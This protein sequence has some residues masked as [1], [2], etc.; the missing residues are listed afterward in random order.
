MSRLIE[1]FNPNSAV[2]GDFASNLVNGCG[3]AVLYNES[4]YTLVLTFEDGSEDILLAWT[5]DVFKARYPSPRIRWRRY[6]TLAVD[7]SPSTRVFGVAYEPSETIAGMYPVG[8]ARGVYVGNTVATNANI[9]NPYLEARV[10]TSTVIGVNFPT[11]PNYGDVFYHQ[12]YGVWFAYN[13]SDWRS[14]KIYYEYSD[15]G[16][17]ISA[18]SV[19]ERFAMLPSVNSGNVARRLLTVE[20]YSAHINSAEY[21][22]DN[23]IR[24]DAED[25]GV[26]SSSVIAIPVPNNTLVNVEQGNIINGSVFLAQGVDSITMLLGQIGGTNRDFNIALLFSI[27]WVYP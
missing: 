11:T 8:L 3:S 4:N 17:V 18:P 5:A 22:N 25:Y 15:S 19:L 6:D 16:H 9:T 20:R 12:Q 21:P 2:A 1:G 24:L 7:A 27:M 10:M 14:H 26:T 23:H 13:G